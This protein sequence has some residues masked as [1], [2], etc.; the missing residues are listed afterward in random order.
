MSTYEPRYED[1]NDDREHETMRAEASSR[2]YE[3]ERC[4]ECGCTN[5]V[6][7]GRGADGL[8]RECVERAVTP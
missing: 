2:A 4:S 6:C 8:C 7:V 3:P 5:R 1:A